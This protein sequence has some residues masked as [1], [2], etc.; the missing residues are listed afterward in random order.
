LR[1]F[2]FEALERP[3]NNG[4]FKHEESLQKPDSPSLPKSADI[5]QITIEEFPFSGDS[6]QRPENKPLRSRGISEGRFE[7]A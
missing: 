3:A 7:D 4:L 6:P 5:L 1:E 2:P